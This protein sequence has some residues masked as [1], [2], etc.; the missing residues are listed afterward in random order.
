MSFATPS[1][2][3]ARQPAKERS[4]RHPKV[5]RGVLLGAGAKVLGNIEISRQLGPGA[6]YKLLFSP[7]INRG[8]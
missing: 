7:P 5:R 6:L 1:I 8:P 3:R 4:D 2:P